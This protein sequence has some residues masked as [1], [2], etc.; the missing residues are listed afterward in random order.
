MKKTIDKC[1]SLISLRTI[2]LHSRMASV[3][4]PPDLL[5]PLFWCLGR[6]L[7][8]GVINGKILSEFVRLNGFDDLGVT[9]IVHKAKIVGHLRRIAEESAGAASTAS[10]ISADAPSSAGI[11][12]LRQSMMKCLCLFFFFA[13]LIARSVCLFDYLFVFVLSSLF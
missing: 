3:E 8:T 12:R 1:S 7:C 10:G 6:F 13:C 4:S 11:K 2:S 5:F 9:N